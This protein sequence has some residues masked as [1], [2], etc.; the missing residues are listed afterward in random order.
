M[1]AV[2]TPAICA[3]SGAPCGTSPSARWVSSAVSGLMFTTAC[4]CP[5]AGTNAADS[6]T[7]EPSLSAAG[8]VSTKGPGPSSTS[9]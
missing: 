1:R 3:A 4:A 6:V 8:A 7:G 5:A 2:V 9:E